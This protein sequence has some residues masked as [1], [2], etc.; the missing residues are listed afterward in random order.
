M[1][2][3][4]ATGV[5]LL[6]DFTSLLPDLHLSEEQ[7]RLWQAA[8]T[9]DEAWRPERVVVFFRSMESVND[10][11]VTGTLGKFF[12]RIRALA[13]TSVASLPA[14]PGPLTPA[15]GASVLAASP[16]DGGSQLS[17]LAGSADSVRANLVSS[18]AQE[19]PGASILPGI[20]A[21]PRRPQSGPIPGTRCVVS[22]A[23]AGG[24]TPGYGAWPA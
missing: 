7:A 16:F 13:H 8:A 1:D 2:T 22:G 14:T 17:F 23:G 9:F 15:L 6:R 4:F 10:P 5:A 20:F 3:Y 12:D 21:T 24:F 11:L 18:F 19:P